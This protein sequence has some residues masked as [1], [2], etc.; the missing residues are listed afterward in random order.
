[1]IT[2]NRVK[3][4]S[5]KSSNLDQ[6]ILP[7]TL[8]TGK[9]G[10]GKTT[11]S[12]AI[13]LAIEGE[14][15]ETGRVGKRIMKLSGESQMKVRVGLSD[16][17]FY[18]RMWKA[19]GESVSSQTA[20]RA[21]DS[22]VKRLN[23]SPL[24]FIEMSEKDRIQTV[25][26][27]S[28]EKL[29]SPLSE[30]FCS[31]M[32][33]DQN[34][35]VWE[36]ATTGR[37]DPYDG[38]YTSKSEMLKDAVKTLVES[39]KE[40]KRDLKR[41]QSAI[42]ALEEK[43]SAGGAP[44]APQESE[45]EEMEK[46]FNDSN[47]HYG[48]LVERVNRLQKTYA[49]QEETKGS[50]WTESDAKQIDILAMEVEKLGGMAS[51]LS[52]IEDKIDSL[53]TR[54]LSIEQSKD[55]TDFIEEAGA[56][57]ACGEPLQALRS[58]AVDFLG[59]LGRIDYENND[60]SK[61]R[62]EAEARLS[63][64]EAMT[65]CPTCGATG[66]IFKG[67]L[68]KEYQSEID[69]M[70]KN[71]SKLAERKKETHEKLQICRGLIENEEKL[72]QAQ[73]HQKRLDENEVLKNQLEKLKDEREAISKAVAD[74]PSQKQELAN[75][76]KKRA[77]DEARRALGDQ[78]DQSE[79]EESLSTI[80]LAAAS[81][82]EK[83]E[84]I[85]EAKEARRALIEFGTQ[86]NLVNEKRQELATTRMRIEKANELIALAEK[87]KSEIVSKL[88]SPIEATL[89][90]FAGRV[91]EAM[92]T[93]SENL[94]LEVADSRGTRSWEALSGSEKTLIAFSLA[95]FFA[96]KSEVKTVLLDEASTMDRERKEVF[97]T[98]V[99]EAVEAG[100]LAQ[101]IVFDHESQERGGWHQIAF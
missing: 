81:L 73:E 89:N 33:D 62:Q 64:I 5:L 48:R 65:S 75:A 15:P 24:K 17:S 11:I 10:S 37:F 98:V 21:A 53:D 72:Q 91:M 61:R 1:M 66:E 83:K 79:I 39:R 93:V 68:T 14:H 54:I 26:E 19:K 95:C 3:A 31:K 47:E 46:D 49:R 8:V 30:D 40:F 101:A 55:L 36:M 57:E 87:A 4:E 84:K 23:F 6:E 99:Q 80:G 13:K 88:V 67:K 70:T 90:R 2:I 41:H 74:L 78:I 29:N 52:G 25:L 32:D 96:E 45:I 12:D 27:L 38:K 82:N 97:M 77:L 9:N 42:Q 7:L 16:G 60:Q 51:E 50:E 69:E 28:G 92:I 56:L 63:E 35:P 18:E 58:A 100:H 85:R 44:I 43:A 86:E 59:D 76:E 22:E 20:G 94:S 71:L 34:L